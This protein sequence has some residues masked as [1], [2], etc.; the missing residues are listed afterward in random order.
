MIE[1]CHRLVLSV[2]FEVTIESGN[3]AAFEAFKKF[4]LLCFFRYC[5]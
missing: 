4:F 5:L 2:G 1:A 3:R